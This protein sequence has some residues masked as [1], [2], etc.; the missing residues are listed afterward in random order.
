MCHGEKDDVVK[1]E[2]GKMSY[3]L[4]KRGHNSI[5]NMKGDRVRRERGKEEEWGTVEEGYGTGGKE[6]RRNI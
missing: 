1:F 6:G 4:L 3:E 2:W 5:L